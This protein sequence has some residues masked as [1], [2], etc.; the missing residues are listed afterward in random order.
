[1]KNF[2]RAISLIIVFSLL[3]SLT[4][5]FDTS[6]MF[7]KHSK[8]KAAENK[9]YTPVEDININIPYISNNPNSVNTTKRI[10]KIIQKV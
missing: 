8:G 9:N 5:C 7:A 10:A 2:K 3:F 1:M 6:E 4:G